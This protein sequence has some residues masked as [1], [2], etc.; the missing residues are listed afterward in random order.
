MR[1]IFIKD[2][3]AR[4]LF[5][6]ITTVLCLSSCSFLKR[7]VIEKYE[8]KQIVTKGYEYINKDDYIDH[9][10]YLEKAYLNT[11]GVEIVNIKKEDLDYL[12]SIF[13][14][15]ARNNELLVKENVIPNIYIIK[16]NTPFYFSLPKGTIFLSLGL[17]QKHISNEGDLVSVLSFEFLKSYNNVYEANMIIPKGFISTER[18]ISLTRVS[19]T[20]KLKINNWMYYILKRSGYDPYIYLTWIQQINKK[21]L[22]FA[23]L[24][25]DLK[26][27]TREE[28]EYKNLLIGKGLENRLTNIKTNSS[29]DYYR[30]IYDIKKIE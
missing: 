27:I 6:A 15:V 3:L 9:L 12:Q 20:E 26:D 13:K 4:F 11:P 18:L 10:A 5:I 30:F 24:L 21:T 2:S 16:N 19:L 8:D 7:N 17:F 1:F 28:I 23:P 14:R 25:G 22:D 29:R